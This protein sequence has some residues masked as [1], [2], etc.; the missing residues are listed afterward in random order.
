MTGTLIASVIAAFVAVALD[1]GVRYIRQRREPFVVPKYAMLAPEPGRVVLDF[2]TND[3]Y[4]PQVRASLV[5]KRIDWR[6]GGPTT[7]EFV[8]KTYFLERNGF[9]G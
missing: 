9:D 1:R 3:Q 5:L 6:R 2:V 7:A 8:D 4:G